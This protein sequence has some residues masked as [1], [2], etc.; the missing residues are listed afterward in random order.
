M[1]E[2][3]QA[4]N[5][6]G[7]DILN[8]KCLHGEVK[9]SSAGNV[10]FSMNSN[11]R[12]DNAHWKTEHVNLMIDPVE[13]WLLNNYSNTVNTDNYSINFNR[14]DSGQTKS[15]DDGYIIAWKVQQLNVLGKENELFT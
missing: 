14:N 9:M 15:P 3:P 12:L 13:F 7:Q 6:S 10:W 11:I 5:F 8:L 1:L 2:R 4:G